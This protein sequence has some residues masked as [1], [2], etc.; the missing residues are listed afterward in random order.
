MK[1]L[2][3]ASAILVFIAITILSL[4]PPRTNLEIPTNDKIGHFMA[5]ATFSLNICLLFPRV[6][7]QLLLLLLGVIGYGIL[8][9]FL[10]GFVG[11]STSFYD[12]LANTIGVS[13]GFVL[14]LFLAWQRWRFSPQM[15]KRRT[16]L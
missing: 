8:L 11:R 3:L 4:L 12:F 13:I 7:K 6:N 2:I 9:E 16:K 5:Y 15:L 1:K 14:Y 10:Q